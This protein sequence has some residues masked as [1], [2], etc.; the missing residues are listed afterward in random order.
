MPE[1]DNGA[2]LTLLSLRHIFLNL[3]NNVTLVGGL[4]RRPNARRSQ[5]TFA[6]ATPRYLFFNVHISEF[7][8]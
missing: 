3:F 2:L 4:V 1:G 7:V 8:Q 5:G 6:A